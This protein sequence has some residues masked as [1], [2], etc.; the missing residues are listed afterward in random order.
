MNSVGISVGRFAPVPVAENQIRP[1]KTLPWVAGVNRQIGTMSPF[2]F[3][4]DRYAS[5][6]RDE[7]SRRAANAM[8]RRAASQRRRDALRVSAVCGTLALDFHEY[9]LLGF[10]GVSFSSTS[11]PPC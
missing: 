1:D 11:L 3:L 7:S 4:A 10:P 9:T 5:R 2:P 8:R 6:L